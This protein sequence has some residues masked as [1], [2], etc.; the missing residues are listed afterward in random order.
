M[1]D[2][3][4]FDRTSVLGALSAYSE[5]LLDDAVRVCELTKIACPELDVEIIADALDK[6]FGILDG[7]DMRTAITVCALALKD[8]REQVV[9]RGLDDSDRWKEELR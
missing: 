6:I 2:E 8:I 3:A 1:K 9:E 5:R 7:R 4:L